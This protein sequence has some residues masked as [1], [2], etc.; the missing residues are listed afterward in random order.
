[1]SYRHLPLPDFNTPEDGLYHVLALA[2]DPPER[3]RCSQV[4][5]AYETS[6]IMITDAPRAVDHWHQ[7]GRTA[8]DL[9]T[10]TT[11]G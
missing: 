4:D 5:V 8:A 7:A 3:G 6:V 10:L 1:M 9:L 11:R 2:C